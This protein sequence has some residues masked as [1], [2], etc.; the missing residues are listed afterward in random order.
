MIRGNGYNDVVIS[1]AGGDIAHFN[2]VRWIDYLGNGLQ[3]FYGNL[4]G[5]AIKDNAVCAVGNEVTGSSTI[6]VVIIIGKR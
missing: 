4:Y 6:Q 2:G 1:G 3:N 5:L